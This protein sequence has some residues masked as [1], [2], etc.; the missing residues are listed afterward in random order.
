MDRR[1]AIVAVDQQEKSV[2]D[3]S[4]W[5]D[6]RKP[7]DK[8]LGVELADLVS[9]TYSIGLELKLPMV[10]TKGWARL[11]HSCSDQSSDM[12]TRETVQSSRKRLADRGLDSSRKNTFAKGSAYMCHGHLMF[13]PLWQAVM[14]TRLATLALGAK[15]TRFWCRNPGFLALILTIFGRSSI[16]V[17]AVMSF[18]LQKDASEFA[19]QWA[20]NFGSSSLKFYGS[21]T[22]RASGLSIQGF[23]QGLSV[24]MIKRYP[25]N[26][27]PGIPL[28]IPVFDAE[29]DKLYQ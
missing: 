16:A 4:Q 2:R 10:F 28:N 19:D 20:Q 14:T 7:I 15:E 26:K 25:L 3:P 9:K 13:T 1:I 18:A 11:T 8:A 29:V 21:V 23:P 5:P 24:E 12:D 6:P 22:V 27:E 17:R